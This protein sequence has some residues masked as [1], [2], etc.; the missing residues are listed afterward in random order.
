VKQNYGTYCV[1]DYV[2]LPLT[3]AKRSA[4]GIIRNGTFPLNI[5]LGRYRG[6]SLEQRLCQNCDRGSRG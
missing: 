6:I 2:V 1:S 4:L 5:E 3:R